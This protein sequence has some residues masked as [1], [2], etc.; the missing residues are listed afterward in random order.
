MKT[1]TV[2]KD[3]LSG[4]P[5][6]VITDTGNRVQIFGTL[7]QGQIWAEWARLQQ[8]LGQVVSNLDVTLIAE[9]NV[10]LTEEYI[11]TLVPFLDENTTQRLIQIVEEKAL[12]VFSETKSDVPE[13][14]EE[15]DR[16][17]ELSNHNKKVFWL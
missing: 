5:F 9:E 10:K 8:S 13:H 14:E 11:Q 3:K 17:N 1:A 4:N 6:A 2:I 15:Y 16:I 7:G 12:L